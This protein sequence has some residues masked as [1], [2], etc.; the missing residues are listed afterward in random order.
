[1]TLNSVSG[2]SFAA[3]PRRPARSPPAARPPPP[4][5]PVQSSLD[6]LRKGGGH[7]GAAAEVASSRCLGAR[8]ARG[9]SARDLI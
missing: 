5:P 8:L 9:Q 7:G 3:T 6:Q 2:E 4:L 1:M